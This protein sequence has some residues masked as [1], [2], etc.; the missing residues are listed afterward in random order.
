MLTAYWQAYRALLIKVGVL[1]MGTPLR[2]LDCLLLVLTTSII[3][4]VLTTGPLT[5]DIVI[6]QRITTIVFLE[7]IRD[8]PY[9]D[10]VTLH[11]L[12]LLF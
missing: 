9:P 10:Q 2:I 6:P 1:V 11:D 4:S 5:P 3:Y 7:N 8:R 12:S